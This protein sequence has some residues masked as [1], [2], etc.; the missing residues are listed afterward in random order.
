MIPTALLLIVIVAILSE[1]GECGSSSTHSGGDG[2]TFSSSSLSGSSNI[3]IQCQREPRTFVN[4][5]T[6]TC[7]CNAIRVVMDEDAD[8]EG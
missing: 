2:G 5:F 4:A 6:S 8:E 1:R 7:I 3:M